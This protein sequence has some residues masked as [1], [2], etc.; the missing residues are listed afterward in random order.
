MATVGKY[1]VPISADTTDFKSV[2]KEIA[3]ILRDAFKNVDGLGKELAKGVDAKDF[4]KIGDGIDDALKDAAK[5]SRKIGEQIGD[6]V[7]AGAESKWGKLG[8]GAK[9][10][11]A[12]VGKVAVGAAAAGGAALAGLAAAS[13]A[14]YADYEQFVGG[15]DKLFGESSSKVQGYAAK[16]FQTAGLSANDYMETV[17]SFSASLIS[18]LGGDTDEAARIADM[19][20]TDMS[21]NANVFGTDMAMLQNTYQGFAKGNFGMLDNLKLGYGGT[22]EEMARLVNEAG[23]LGD[24]FVAT[25]QNVKDIPF[26]TLIESINVVQQR[27]NITG[28][29][30]KEGSETIAGSLAQVQAGWQNVVTGFA[31]GGDFL[32]GALE[33]FSTAV[34]SFANNVLAILPQVIAGI[35]TAITT[36]IPT[37]MEIVVQIIPELANLLVTGLPVLLDAIITA[38]PGLI[39]VLMEAITALFPI[40]LQVIVDL[41]LAIVTALPSLITSIV[42]F[43]VTAIPQLVTAAIQLFS[44]IIQALPQVIIALLDALPTLIVAI[45]TNL[46]SQVPVLIEAALLMFYAIVTAL[47]KIIPA[48]ILMIPNIIS[49]LVTEFQKQA[50]ALAETGLQM[51]AGLA[52]GLKDF[53]FFK[54]IGDI[55]NNIINGFKDFFG[56]KSPSRL[57]R[58]LIGKQIGAGLAVGIDESQPMVDSAVD[59]ISTDIAIG[60]NAN[61]EAVGSITGA[62]RAPSITVNQT[63]NEP[64]SML[65]F[66]LQTQKGILLGNQLVGAA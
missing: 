37:L 46:V 25:G 66:Q 39:T 3:N 1:K 58:D 8:D 49:S 22:Q 35:T 30:A 59:D 13:V 29:T 11:L 15:V 9:S 7:T 43:L 4:D 51:M 47:P 17:T 32:T 5:D 16:A 45:V 2:G 41:A 20:I 6:E 31:V 18:G 27:M 12:G 42:T 57:M 54:I 60:V 50:P 44:G 33:G 26:A 55:G 52:E 24:S 21:D 48:L 10:A 62:Y 64:K 38:L 61:T 34:G 40:L 65:D 53:D 56:I 28:T 14:S 19:A 36:L 23:L 63:V